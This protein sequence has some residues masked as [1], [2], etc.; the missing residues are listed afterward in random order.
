MNLL[1][2]KFGRLQVLRKVPSHNNL[3]L[4]LF[5]PSN[6]ILDHK[7]RDVA[8]YIKY[9]FWT[10]NNH[11][12]FQELDEYFYHNF[13]S[14]YGIRVLFARILYPSFYFD[15]YDDIISGKKEEKEL[16]TIIS[17]I[18]EYEYY[19]YN[20]FMYLNKFYNIP[21]IEWLKK[22]GINPR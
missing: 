15:I 1:G 3:Y 2:Q 4:S 9:H 14:I 16:N 18:D 21:E 11:N 20:S 8:E 19:L 7:A 13:Y 12:I 6:M 22:Q 17:K 5:D 10:N